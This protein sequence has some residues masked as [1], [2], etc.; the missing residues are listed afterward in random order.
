MRQYLRTAWPFV[1]T[2]PETDRAKVVARLKREG[3][4]DVTIANRVH[5]GTRSMLDAAL[6]HFLELTFLKSGDN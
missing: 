1:M 3:W 6:S 4:V 5:W 2:K